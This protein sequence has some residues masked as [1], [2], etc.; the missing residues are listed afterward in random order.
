MGPIVRDI[1]FKHPKNIKDFLLALADVPKE[2]YNKIIA[3]CNKSNGR[4]KL[5]FM[6]NDNSKESLDY[7]CCNDNYWIAICYML[8]NIIAEFYGKVIYT[9]SISSKK[10]AELL[11]EYVKTYY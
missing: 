10:F 3:K 5:D 4:L 1:N 6:R 9:Y 8:F 2:N 11:R 7:D